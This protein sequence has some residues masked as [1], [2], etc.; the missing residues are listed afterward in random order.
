MADGVDLD[1]VSSIGRSLWGN[2]SLTY[3]RV[4]R[5]SVYDRSSGSSALSFPCRDCESEARVQTRTKSL[6]ACWTCGSRPLS[7]A[8]FPIIAST[9]AANRSLFAWRNAA[10]AGDAL[11]NLYSKGKSARFERIF[12]RTNRGSRANGSIPFPVLSR[13]VYSMICKL[14]TKLS[15]SKEAELVGENMD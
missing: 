15:P 8:G 4:L 14:S 11:C 13:V 1:S 7:R 5:I 9:V 12:C 10:T 6:T 3:R 2:R